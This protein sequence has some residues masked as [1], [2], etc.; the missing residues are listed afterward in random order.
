LHHVYAWELGLNR[1][2]ATNK[3]GC[4]PPEFRFLVVARELINVMAQLQ[5][6]T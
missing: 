1:G 3:I 4:G 5:P 2:S 6:S